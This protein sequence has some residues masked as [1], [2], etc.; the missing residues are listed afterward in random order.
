M[1]IK[2]ISCKHVLSFKKGKNE[3]KGKAEMARTSTP[4]S[5]PGSRLVPSWFQRVGASLGL[6]A[7]HLEG[8]CPLWIA[9]GWCQ[10]GRASPLSHGRGAGTPVD[11]EP[12]S[13]IL[14]T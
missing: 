5:S 2:L 10:R 12:K 6:V 8:G 3:S 13:I 11:Q 14:K 1:T 9:A 4:I 7:Q